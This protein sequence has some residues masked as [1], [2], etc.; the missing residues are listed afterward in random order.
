MAYY[1]EGWLINTF[2]NRAATANVSA[3]SDA[4]REG[5]ILEGRALVCDSAHN[6]LVDFNGIRG[7]H[8]A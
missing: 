4:M 6:L 5:R 1:P 8:S 3:L 7:H 2:Q